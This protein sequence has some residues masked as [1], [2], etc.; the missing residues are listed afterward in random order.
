MAC[1]N[2]EMSVE[3]M[4]EGIQNLP[5]DL[6]EMTLVQLQGEAAT[7]SKQGKESEP[8]MVKM[9]LRNVAALLKR[10]EDCQKK[11]VDGIR[12]ALAKLEHAADTTLASAVLTIILVFYLREAV[13]DDEFGLLV[14]REKPLA[15]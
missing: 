5:C 7:T 11:L 15:A 14:S 4:A 9:H 2:L 1:S 3:A 6:H 10:S 8:Q 13:I 12:H